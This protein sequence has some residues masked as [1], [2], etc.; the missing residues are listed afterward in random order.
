MNHVLMILTEEKITK[1][2][3]LERIIEHD[4]LNIKANDPKELELA[5]ISI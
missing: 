3:G 5:T 1:L 2:L 4:I